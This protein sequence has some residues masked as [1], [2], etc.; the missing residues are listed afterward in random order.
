LARSPGSR[1]SLLFLVA[2]PRWPADHSLDSCG[3]QDDGWQDGSSSSGWQSDGGNAMYGGVQA[4][5]GWGARPCSGPQASKQ[6]AWGSQQQW[7][8]LPQQQ[9]ACRPQQQLDCPLCSQPIPEEQP[10]TPDYESVYVAGYK[11]GYDAASQTGCKATAR[12]ISTR[13]RCKSSR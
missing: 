2:M 7:A 6:L 3:S 10:L 9:L 11:A 8:C 5:E 13:S 12:G 4:A 1:C